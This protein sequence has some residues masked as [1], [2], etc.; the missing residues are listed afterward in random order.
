MR[1]GVITVLATTLHFV[2]AT[3]PS[4]ADGPGIVPPGRPLTTPAYVRANAREIRKAFSDRLVRPGPG[5]RLEWFGRDGA[6]IPTPG[7]RVQGRYRI[8]DGWICTPAP[9]SIVCREVLKDPFGDFYYGK[10]A[11]SLNGWRSS[12]SAKSLR[13][14]FRPAGDLLVRRQPTAA[15]RVER[16]HWLERPSIDLMEDIYPAKARAQRVRGRAMLA[17]RFDRTARPVD[18]KVISEYPTSFG[19][20]AVAISLSGRMRSGDYD[21]NGAAVAGR[22]VNVAFAFHPPGD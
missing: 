9:R 11:S 21:E 6:Y 8:V 15:T 22:P 13:L 3:A 19:F 1:L 4:R 10:V 17:C 12:G 16:P 7:A 20:G 18:C 5:E 2:G 14:E